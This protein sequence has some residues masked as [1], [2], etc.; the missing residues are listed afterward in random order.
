MPWVGQGLCGVDMWL[1]AH[2]ELAPGLGC[3]AGDAASC[4]HLTQ[5]ADASSELVMAG[6][7]SIGPAPC[8]CISWLFGISLGASCYLFSLHPLVILWSAGFC[9]ICCRCREHG[10]RRARREP[11]PRG[12]AFGVTRGSRSGPGAQCVNKWVREAASLGSRDGLQGGV[13]TAPP[14][15]ALLL[16]RLPSWGREKTCGRVGSA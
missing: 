3:T 5:E 7:A 6:Q 9:F 10:R 8:V 16:G 4:W 1:R 15:T 11:T 14:L 2:H 13:R 12:I